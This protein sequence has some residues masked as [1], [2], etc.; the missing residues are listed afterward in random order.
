MSL[1]IYVL[2]FAVVYA[3]VE[4]DNPFLLRN[5]LLSS[6]YPTQF[7]SRQVYACSCIDRVEQKSANP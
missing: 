1:Y 7:H 5:K 4:V 2:W 6:K 3:C